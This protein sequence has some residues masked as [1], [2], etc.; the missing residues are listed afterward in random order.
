MEGRMG[1]DGEWD[2]RSM[3]RR[4]TSGPKVKHRL[5]M[6]AMTFHFFC[7][8]MCS[9]KFSS[10]LL[11]RGPPLPPRSASTMDLS[12]W[13]SSSRKFFVFSPAE[14]RWGSDLGRLVDGAFRSYTYQS[15]GG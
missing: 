2:G 14:K 8:E 3:R 12:V 13:S 9:A 7:D 1:T 11:A 6:R 5:P 4:V 15:D 10:M